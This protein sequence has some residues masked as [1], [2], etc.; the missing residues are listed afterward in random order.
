[1]VCKI[2][3]NSCI[4]RLVLFNRCIVYL[5]YSCIKNVQKTCKNVQKHAK[6][7]H[8]KYLLTKK[9]AS[10]GLIYQKTCKN[11]KK[12]EKRAKTCKNMHLKC[13]WT[14]FKNVHCQGPCLRPCISRPYC[15]IFRDTGGP[16]ISWFHN[17]WSSQ[18][19]NSILCTHLVNS[20]EFRDFEN[21]QKKKKKIGI[22]SE[23]FQTFF[24]MFSSQKQF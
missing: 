24:C 4:G 17:S 12:R 19:R 11:V 8:L 10:Q 18:I 1:M 14:L 20:S 2:F 6:N 5:K 13:F 21:K 16:R 9:R 23:F 22:F 15:I 7:V 3:K